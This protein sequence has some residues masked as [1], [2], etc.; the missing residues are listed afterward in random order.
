MF[1][2]QYVKS[3][4]KGQ[5]TRFRERM[6]DRHGCSVALVRKWE[7]WPPPPEWSEE[8]VKAEVRRHPAQLASI[9]ITEELTHNHVTRRELRPEC[10]ID[11]EQ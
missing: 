6:A 4:P 8:K 5:R 9:R 7:N 3:L 2:G 11:E 10:W 1:L